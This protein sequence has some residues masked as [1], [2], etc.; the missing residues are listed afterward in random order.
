MT[1]FS[2]HQRE[3]QKRKP[4]GSALPVPAEEAKPKLWGWVVRQTNDVLSGD[5]A[6]IPATKSSGYDL[7]VE[8][9]RL[10]AENRWASF[11]IVELFEGSK[12]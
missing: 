10:R 3:K 4:T 7:F 1:L 6:A 9:E 5:F 2:E 12:S 11:E 8:V